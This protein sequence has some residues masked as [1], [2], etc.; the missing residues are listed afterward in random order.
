MT[1]LMDPIRDQGPLFIGAVALFLL[2][3][4]AYGGVSLRRHAPSPI[5]RR[6][7][8]LLFLAAFGVATALIV[9]RWIA[10]GRPPFKTLHESL[11]LFSWCTAL[12]YIAV[13]RFYRIAWFGAIT[14]LFITGIYGYALAKADVEVV[15]LPAALQSVW[16]V[17]H[18][19][20]YFL[21]YGAMFLAFLAAVMHLFKPDTT[22][23]LQ[24]PGG[25]SQEMSYA[26]FM[27]RAIQFGFILLTIGLVIG[28]IW[29]E[30]AWGSYW[31][32]DP[33][34]NWALVSWLVFLIYLHLRFTKG[35]SERTGAVLTVVGFATV[36]FTYLG[37]QLLPT[38]EQSAHVY[39]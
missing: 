20:V 3:A 5:L 7:A 8:S 35:F 11:L 22:V 30:V 21:G 32:W 17:P 15:N 39:Q 36:V 6:V 9:D 26:G 1:T 10:Y 12:V 34:E 25:G 28:A 2:A 13:E 16:F 29:A 27:H 31:V 33:K 24:T 18:V 23:E 14:S 38:A 4:A 37:M 19:V